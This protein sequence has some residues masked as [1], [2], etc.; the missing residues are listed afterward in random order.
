VAEGAE[1]AAAEGA[2][3]AAGGA[4]RAADLAAGTDDARF[5][6][7]ER[8]AAVLVS[9]GFPPMPARVFVALLVT[10]SG[11][12]SAA[13]LAA[14]LRISPAAVSGGVRYLIQ[15]GLVHKERVPGSRRDYYRMPGNMWDDLL[16][17]RDQVMSRW[18]ALVREGIELVGADTPAGERMAEQAAFLEFATKEVSQVL[19]RWEDYQ[20]AGT[21][22]PE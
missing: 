4:E 2:E 11:R 14:M 18:T 15:L 6:Y 20:A 13:E 10:D 3:L 16:R 9:A 5:G 17:M 1:A 12:L 8:F 19:S 22:E 7:I 21:R